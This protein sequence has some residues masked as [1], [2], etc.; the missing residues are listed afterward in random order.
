MLKMNFKAT[1]FDIVNSLKLPPPQIGL[2]I[3]DEGTRAFVRLSPFQGLP[4]IYTFYGDNSS[5]ET[6]QKLAILKT[7]DVLKFIHQFEIEDVGFYDAQAYK[8]SYN[9]GNKRIDELER[10]IASLKELL[11]ARTNPLLRL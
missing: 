7:I 5:F 9:E 8:A 4:D 3:S 2:E 11:R 6:A 10:E 1:L